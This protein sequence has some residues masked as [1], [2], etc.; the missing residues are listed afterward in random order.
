MWELP[1]L[2][3]LMKN[4]LINEIPDVRM[5]AD[6]ELMTIEPHCRGLRAIHSPRTGNVN[7]QAVANAYGED[8]VQ[9]GGQIRTGFEVTH[10]ESSMDHLDYPILIRG[11]QRQ[12]NQR[13]P[14]ELQC[15]YLIT[16]AGLQGDRVARMT[17]CPTIPKIIP[18]R[19]DFM[20]LKPEKSHLVRGNI[21][22]V[23]DARFP[24]LGAHFNSGLGESVLLGP[25][26]VLS[27]RREGYGLMDFNLR[28]AVESLTYPGLQR[29]I[30]KYFGVGMNE[31]MRAFSIRAQMKYL[32]R[33]IPEISAE[34]VTRG[35]SGIRAQAV[36]KKGNLLDD[37]IMHQGTGSAGW[38]IV[39]VLG[40]PSPGATSS[41][42]IARLLISKS[43]TQ[44]NWPSTRKEK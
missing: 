2:E 40:V 29:M 39:H 7:W 8:F 32:Q 42:P 14:F 43:E 33:F 6:D 10:I 30:Y 9:S 16:C 18:F 27:L 15:K 22:P 36:D 38:R 12:G 26:A 1:I 37:F 35:P 21:Y 28:D 4:A 13:R 3:S 11:M 44:F 34:D 20:I 19:G 31:W 5:I 17:G 41:L 24:F 23:P 25:N